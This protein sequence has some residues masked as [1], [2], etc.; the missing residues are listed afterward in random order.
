METRFYFP[1]RLK[2]L[3]EYFSNLKIYNLVLKIFNVL[4]L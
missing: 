2:D 3:F 1:K 4:V